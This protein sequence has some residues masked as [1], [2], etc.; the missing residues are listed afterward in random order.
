MN[1]QLKVPMFR[2][3]TTNRGQRTSGGYRSKFESVVA[4]GLTALGLP[5]TYEEDKLKYEVPARPATYTPDFK[6]GDIYIEAKGY[7]TASDRKKMAAVKRCHPEKDIRLLFQRPQNFIYKGSKTTYSQW[8]EAEGF[9]WA[10]GP[11]VP[12]SWLPKV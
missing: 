3:R 9:P 6:I 5:F 8:A 12:A 1:P 7:L 10:Q 4:Q 11:K 2:R